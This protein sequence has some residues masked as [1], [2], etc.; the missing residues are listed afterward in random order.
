MTNTRPDIT[1]ERTKEIQDLMQQNP[2]WNRSRISIEICKLWQWCSPNG[3]PKDIACRDLLRKLDKEGVIILPA[4]QKPANARRGSDKIIH[5]EH[6]K[7]QI[8]VKLPELLP[9]RFNIV[10]TKEEL[11]IFKSYID[12]FHYLGFGRCVGE[13]MKYIIYSQD[14]TPLSCM[15]FG[16][17]AWACRPRDEYIGWDASCRQSNLN[18]TTNQTRFLIFPWVKVPY[19]ASHIL[20]RIVRRI[21]EDW[22]TKYGHPVYLVETFVDQERFKGISYRAANWRFVGCTTG[23]GRNSVS[24]NA[25]LPIKGVY[26]YPL[27]RG[28]QQKLTGKVAMV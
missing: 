22:D 10:S 12:Q 7:G 14:G 24:S 19:L 3:K 17:S 25:V 23:R 9:L 28:Y 16:S 4:S 1:E 11:V 15:L 21:A 2:G 20:S 13:N 8:N 18:L 27:V 26:L 6:D 5:L